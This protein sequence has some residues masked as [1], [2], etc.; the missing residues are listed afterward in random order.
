MFV[1]IIFFL[2]L[3]FGSFISSYTWRVGKSVNNKNRSICPKC[4]SQI[5]WI[6]NF[7]LVSYILLNGKCKNCKKKIS[8]RYPLIETCTGLI[9]AFIYYSYAYCTSHSTN[10]ICGLKGEI[11]LFTLPYLLIISVI[12]ICIFV[13]DIEKMIIPDK[14]SFLGFLVVFLVLML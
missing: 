10:F 4:K 9:F 6:D 8:L 2:G 3:I 5:S 14:L 12:L 11:G 13:I 1:L 7:P